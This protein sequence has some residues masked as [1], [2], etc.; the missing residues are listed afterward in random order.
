[1]VVVD[2]LRADDRG[3]GAERLLDQEPDRGRV[4]DHVVVAEEEEGRALDDLD[5]VV[6]RGGEARGLG[7]PA[8]EGAGQHA[9]PTRAVGSTVDPASRTS[10]VSAG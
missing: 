9:R 7:E 10:A 5:H 6:G 4:D 2:Q 1:M 3:V 8:D